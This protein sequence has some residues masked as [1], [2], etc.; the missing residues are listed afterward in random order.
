MDNNIKDIIAAVRVHAKAHYNEG[1]WDYVV[2]AYDDSEILE[3]I[4]D[5]KTAEEAIRNIGKIL[6]LRDDY[7]KDIEA[8]AF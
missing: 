1:G 4:G 3:E 6:K 8:S 2:E 5:A 7:R